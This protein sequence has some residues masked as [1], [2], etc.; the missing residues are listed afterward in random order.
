MS[1]VY[2]DENK[3]AFTKMALR[4][5]LRRNYG[6]KLPVSIL[7][8]R[9]S[10]LLGSAL[11]I[12]PLSTWHILQRQGMCRVWIKNIYFIKFEDE[13]P[14]NNL[15]IQRFWSVKMLKVFQKGYCK[16]VPQAINVQSKPWSILKLY[17]FSCGN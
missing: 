17:K 14:I 15:K 10:H 1:Q 8:M 2:S 3:A 11:L 12:V 13:N 9:I 6:K 16:E 4:K 7:E 5:I